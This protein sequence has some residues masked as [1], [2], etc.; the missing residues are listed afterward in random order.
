MKSKF[1]KAETK[2]LIRLKHSQEYLNIFKKAEGR[3]K[4]LK[5]AWISLSKE[6]N[7]NYDYLDVTAKYN[8][9]L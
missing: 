3:P 9:L 7:E 8:Q 1:N 2:N 6:I 5:E 4:A